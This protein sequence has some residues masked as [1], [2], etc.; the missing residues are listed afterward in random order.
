VIHQLEAGICWINAWG[1][2]T[3]K[4]RWAAT[5]SRAWAAKTASARCAQYTRIKSVQVELGDYASVF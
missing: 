3:Q 1:E 4:C 5:S 2:S